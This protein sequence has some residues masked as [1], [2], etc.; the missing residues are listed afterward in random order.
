MITPLQAAN[1]I[2]A[3]YEGSLTAE[4]RLD[5]NGC[6]S[7]IVNLPNNPLILLIRG[8]DERQDWVR[9]FTF[10][11]EQEPGDSGVRWHRGFLEHS[12]IAYSWARDKGVELVIGHSLGGACVQIVA[13]SL[14]VPGMAFAAPRALWAPPLVG[15]RPAN[16]ALVT[17]YNRT[18]DLVCE[19]PLVTMGFDHAGI[20]NAMMPTEP[21]PGEDHRI[22]NY[23]ALLEEA[24]A[25]AM[26]DG[27][28]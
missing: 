28:L 25:A 7:A 1:L 16:E 21:H 18:D 27:T 20:V 8:S 10:V 23:I 4:S 22:A 26:R 15:K 12:R 19:V 11:P 14:K 6:Q 17:C 13:T 24:E 3:D 5:I 9:N 2:L